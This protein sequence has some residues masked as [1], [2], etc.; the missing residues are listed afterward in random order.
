[1]KARKRKHSEIEAE[2][3][4]EALNSLVAKADAAPSVASRIPY[5]NGYGDFS[6]GRLIDSHDWPDTNEER[7]EYLSEASYITLP[8][9]MISLE[10]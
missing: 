5:N 2:A 7:R 8:Q 4:P 6:F 1:M 10:E 9:N 3:V